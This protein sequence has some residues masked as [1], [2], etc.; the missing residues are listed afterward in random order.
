[1]LMRLDPADS[2]SQLNFT[3]SKTQDGGGEKSQYLHNGLTNFDKIWHGD[4]TVT[5]QKLQKS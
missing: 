4:V 5:H 3:I 2:V 1:M